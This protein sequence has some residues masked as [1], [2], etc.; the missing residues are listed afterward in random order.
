M[1]VLILHYRVT[2]FNVLSVKKKQ[3]TT[4]TNKQKNPDKTINSAFEETAY[5]FVHIEPSVILDHTNIYL[6][7]LSSCKGEQ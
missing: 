1:S 6:L 3:K 2:E 5:R 7:S 4:T